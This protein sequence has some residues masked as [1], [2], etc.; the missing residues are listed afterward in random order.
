MGSHGA[1][2][3]TGVLSVHIHFQRRFSG[4]KMQKNLISRKI[5]IRQDE[6]PA[7]YACFLQR[8]ADAGDM[9]GIYCLRVRT[10]IVVRR[11]VTGALKLPDAGNLNAIPAGIVV[12]GSGTAFGKGLAFLPAKTP[13]PV[14]RKPRRREGKSQGVRP[15]RIREG[16]RMAVFLVVLEY[17]GVFP[18]G[19]VFFHA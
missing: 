13:F 6:C 18:V 14:K 17:R 15:V 19:V 10:G 16:R 7:V 8:T 11:T 12:V 5:M 4:A 9:F 2:G 1:F 3:K